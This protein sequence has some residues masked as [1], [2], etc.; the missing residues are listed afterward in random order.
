MRAQLNR[1]PRSFE[2][3][4]DRLTPAT[5]AFFAVG[6]L[7][8]VG[9]AA[10]NNIEVRSVNG[11]LQVSDNGQAVP[12][13]SLGTPRLARTVAVVV[14]GRAG[15]DTVKLDVSLGTVAAAVSGGAG[16]DVLTAAHNGNSALSGDDGDDVL[17]GGGGRDLLLGGAGNDV[18][19]GGAGADALYGGAGDDLL[20]GGGADG[21]P[22]LLVGG[23]GADIF[24]NHA[25]EAD[26]FFDV[27][28]DEGD[29]IV[30][31]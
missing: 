13:R 18:L 25:G 8:V 27:D 3:L 23:P 6:V 9:D 22:D 28:P 20:D 16:N 30:N 26:I 29:L 5:Q 15:D 14:A 4:E 24:L 1:S 2:Q 12:I 21:S 7:T 19:N 17:N 11:I 10:N 31:V